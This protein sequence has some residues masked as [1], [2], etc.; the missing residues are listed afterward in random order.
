[1]P[2]KVQVHVQHGFFQYEVD[3]VARAM[4]H[5]EAIMQTRTYRHVDSESSVTVYPVKKVKLVGE[6]L[7]TAYPAEF[8]RT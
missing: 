3:T 8:H 7:G 4:E 5:A 6:N 2:V 1:M